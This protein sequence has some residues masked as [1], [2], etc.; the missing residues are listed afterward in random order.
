METVVGLDREALIA[1]YRL[2][3]GRTEAW[4]D[5][6][7]PESYTARPIALR[8]PICFYEG[9]IPA[10]AVNTLL[11]G[12]LGLPGI[13]PD[14]EVLFERG[15][16]PEDESHVPAAAS[17]WPSRSEI[18]RYAE[19]AD[20]A[21][22]DALANGD[23]EDDENPRTRRGLAAYTILEHEGMHQETLAYIWS[24]LAYDQKIRPAG[25]SDPILGLEPPTPHTVRIPEGRATLGA[26][27]EAFGWD[28]EF[29]RHV[30]E[31]PS[32]SLDA[33]SVTNR[34]FLEFVE[35]GGYGDD[36]LWG[37][38]GFARDTE[39]RYPV[40]WEMHR[41]RWFWR[42]QWGLLPLPMAWPVYVSHD[43]ARAYA[44][45]KERRLM[46]EPEFHRAAYG[47]PSGAERL[48]PWGDEPPDATRGNFDGRHAD[49]VPVGSYPGGQSAWGIHDLVGNGWEWTDTVFA[50]FPGF[51][52]MATYPR[53]SA[54]FF[55]GKHF[56]MKGAS[57]ATPKELVRR[58]FRNWFFG[59]YPY[60]YA[61][62]RLASD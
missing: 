40:F 59:N 21:I 13:D 26:D 41:G 34:D 48:Q 10:F 16:D 51:A 32:F 6:V 33:H 12:A 39:A 57:P 15:I 31:V 58:S 47:T 24:R 2:N 61:K 52:P 46:T 62:F 25:V 56:V 43:E 1:W 14:L 30:V 53:Y 5:S 19:A 44:R 9:H 35:A 60:M 45:W 27:P 49:P 36:D 37:D 22:V 8:N 4:F 3:R 11:K 18:G 7:R 23:I 50:P 28:N 54:D 29:P 55:D 42:A 17:R 20:R 38:E